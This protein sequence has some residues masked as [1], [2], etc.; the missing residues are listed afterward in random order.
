MDKEI[1]VKEIPGVFLAE[2]VKLWIKNEYSLKKVTENEQPK[3]KDTIIVSEKDK[4]VYDHNL[5]EILV[6]EEFSKE[7]FR[8]VSHEV[9]INFDFYYLRNALE[10]AKSEKVSTLFTGSSYGLF[11]IDRRLLTNAA[12][13]SMTSQDL[14]YSICG[15]NEVL[16]KNQKVKNIVLCCSYYYFFS[17]FSMSQNSFE[18]GLMSQIYYPLFKDMHNAALV[19][20]RNSSLPQSDLFDIESVV[21]AISMKEYQKGY[22]TDQRRRAGF[23][24]RVWSNSARDWDQLTVLDKEEAGK[25]RA[26]LHN[27]SIMRTATYEEN[28]VLFSKLVGF[29]AERGINF[30]CLVPPA[31]SYYRKALNPEFKE[32]FYQTI[33]DTDGVI[34]LIDL[35]DNSCFAEEDFNDTDHLSESGA[36]KLTQ[37]VL[38]VLET[39]RH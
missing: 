16:E 23:A 38:Q 31:T 3:K 1:W 20:P 4:D 27:K 29:C 34:H 14:F 39:I 21:K 2:T 5:F 22:F 35:F 10:Y 8:Y 13:L 25:I 32:I 15:I 7:L 37:Y 11:G 6:Y 18:R 17:D 33:N 12:N 24:T 28:I 30:I 9:G 19:L 36:N 26:E